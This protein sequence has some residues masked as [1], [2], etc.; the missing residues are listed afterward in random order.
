VANSRRRNPL[1]G[2]QLQFTPVTYFAVQSSQNYIRMP[3]GK[4]EMQITCAA[5]H[6][7]VELNYFSIVGL[8]VLRALRS[9]PCPQKERERQ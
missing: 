2:N 6:P 4:G 7:T 1:L 5:A 3:P 8:A 9:Q